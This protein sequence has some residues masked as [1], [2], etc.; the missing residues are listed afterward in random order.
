MY[1]VTRTRRAVEIQRTVSNYFTAANSSLHSQTRPSCKMLL[2][3]I[4]IPKRTFFRYF[5]TNTSLELSQAEANLSLI[6]ACPSYYPE[7]CPVS[8]P[9]SLRGRHISQVASFASI[10]GASF[11]SLTYDTTHLLMIL[12]VLIIALKSTSQTSGI[13]ESHRTAHVTLAAIWAHVL[14]P[15]RIDPARLVHPLHLRPSPCPSST[16][17]L[18]NSPAIGD[19]SRDGGRYLRAVVSWHRVDSAREGGHS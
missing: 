18:L 7:L 15:T 3:I 4:R 11:R 9:K 6:G 16:L 2:Q 8:K 19:R 10:N 1:C 17:L 14:Y 13:G 5:G 12:Q